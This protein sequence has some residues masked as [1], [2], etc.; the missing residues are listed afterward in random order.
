MRIEFQARVGPNPQVSV[1]LLDWSCRQSAHVLDCLANQSVPRE[2]YE[3]IWVEYYN[4]LSECLKN[5]LRSDCPAASARAVDIAAVLE[6]PDG[7]CYHKHMMLN[8]GLMLARGQIVCFADSDAMMRRTFVESILNAFDENGDIVLHFDEVRN[9]DSRFYPFNNPPLREIT[10]VGSIN[11]LNGKPTGLLDRSDLLHMRNY[12]ACMAAL[13]SSLIGIGGSDMHMDYLGHVCGFY[14]MTWRLVNAGKRERWHDREWLYHVWHPG[15]NG[16]RNFIGPHD[17][18]LVSKR[19]L[20]ARQTGRVMP[21][22]E[23]PAIEALRTGR[24]TGPDS[25]APP[26]QWAQQLAAVAHRG[27][28]VYSV[29]CRRIELN[30]E[31]DGGRSMRIIRPPSP[32]GRRCSLKHKVRLLP[33]LGRIMLRQFVVKRQ[34]AAY[35][36]RGRGKG[37]FRN[38]IRLLQATIGFFKRIR[39]YNRHWARQC[40]LA[41]AYAAQEGAQEVVVLGQGDEVEIIKRLAPAAGIAISGIVPLHAE[42]A[43][44]NGLPVRKIQDIARAEDMI[45]IAAFAGIDDALRVAVRAGIPRGRIITLA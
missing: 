23:H 4:Q 5:K 6:M 7:L 35:I 12:G 15:E 30:V 33:T 17:G 2:R 13:R 36:G 37:A 22:V 26:A 44:V 21:F 40:W 27:S 29:G 14:E 10:G 43:V 25:F 8:A 19:A 20:I 38:A 41:L 42:A 24:E 39:Q 16:H 1:V 31:S 28:V 3:I 11:W 32:F 9:S 34:A 45:I 18:L